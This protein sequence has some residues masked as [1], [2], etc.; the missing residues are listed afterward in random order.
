MRS[1]LTENARVLETRLREIV[2]SVALGRWVG[3][4]IS[5]WYQSPILVSLTGDTFD[6]FKT[7]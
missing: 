5:G 2:V 3:C 6:D 1:A 7:I 4:V